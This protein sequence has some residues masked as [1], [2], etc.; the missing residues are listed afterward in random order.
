[1]IPGGSEARS[2]Q[3]RSMRQLAE[4]NRQAHFEGVMGRIDVEVVVQLVL[5]LS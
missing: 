2:R 3:L 5:V 4:V 1:M